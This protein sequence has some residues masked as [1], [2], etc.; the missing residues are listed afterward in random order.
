MVLKPIPYNHYA[1][2]V[3]AGTVHV[4]M[5]L[6]AHNQAAIIPKPS[7]GSFNFPAFSIPSQF[8]AALGLG[9]LSI[10][11]MRPSQINAA[12]A[13]LSITYKEGNQARSATLSVSRYPR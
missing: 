9:F 13:Y 12:W 2:K 3:K 1:G 6:M 8:P 7:E 4:N 10:A 5:P 11:S